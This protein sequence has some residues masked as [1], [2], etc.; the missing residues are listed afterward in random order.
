[1]V[2]LDKY[3]YL[4]NKSSKSYFRLALLQYKLKLGSDT[5]SLQWR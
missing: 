5:Q 4:Y 2:M 1:M 3:L